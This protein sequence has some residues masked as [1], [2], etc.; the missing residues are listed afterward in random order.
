ME[1]ILSEEQKE[2]RA[3]E[4]WTRYKKYLRIEVTLLIAVMLG[5]FTL[6]G[7]AHLEKYYSTLGVPIDRLNFSA[8][9][10]AAYGG[11]GVSSVLAALLLGVALG[12]TIVLVTALCQKPDRQPVSPIPLPQWAINILKRISELRFSFKCTFIAIVLA[13]FAYAVWY[14]MV[15]V[16]SNS[17][18]RSALKAAAECQERTLRFRNLDSYSGCLVAE[19]EDMFYLIKRSTVDDSSVTFKSFQIP[20]VGLVKSETKDL[21]RQFEE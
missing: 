12:F 11:A 14:L 9:K 16:P 20:K 1:S 4:V 17:G 10:V 8:Q 21:T 5:V 3:E 19:S 6:N 7:Y 2:L 18:R 13:L 15:T